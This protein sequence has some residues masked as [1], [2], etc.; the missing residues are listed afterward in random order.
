[1][2]RAAFQLRRRST[3]G[4]SP[5]VPT[6]GKSERYAS[7]ATAMAQ[8]KASPTK[9]RVVEKLS[10]GR[11]TGE[12]SA[13]A[14]RVEIRQWGQTS[15]RGEVWEARARSHGVGGRFDRH[16]I[17]QSLQS[18]SNSDDDPKCRRRP[19]DL[20]A[21]LRRERVTPNEGI[22]RGGQAPS[23]DRSLTRIDARGETLSARSQGELA[24]WLTARMSAELYKVGVVA[25]E[26][27]GGRRQLT[28]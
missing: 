5:V 8:Q 19:Q 7:V 10:Y 18:L 27:A 17:R 4:W 6:P 28:F 14:H 11:F 9:R 25:Y 26:V 22:R 12:E 24:L 2:R 16:L 21:L 1:M 20:G 23:M 15:C 3:N 13:A